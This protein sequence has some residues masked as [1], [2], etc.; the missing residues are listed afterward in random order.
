MLAG[1]LLDIAPPLRP[2]PPELFL[3]LGKVKCHRHLWGGGLRLT[4]FGGGRRGSYHKPTKAQN[5][6]W[7]KTQNYRAVL[8]QVCLDGCKF[9]WTGASLFGRVQVCLDGC[10]FVWTGA[11]CLD[12]CSV[13]RVQCLDG[14]SVWTQSLDG[15]RVWTGAEFGR[16]QSLDGC[17]VWTG[18]EFGRVQS[19]D[20]CSV[21]TGAVFGRVQCLDG[22][23]VWTG[24]EVFARV[25]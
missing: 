21:W 4:F 13:G 9:V 7:G 25:Q 24:A 20:G 10:K 19:L 22:C 18:A 23:S 1:V 3:T 6:T 15:C 14:C 11:V 2:P 17:R 8:V 12:G 16:V 5:S